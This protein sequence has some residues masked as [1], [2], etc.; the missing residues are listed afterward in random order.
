MSTIVT[1]AGKGS[2]LTWNEADNNFTNLNTDK[3]QSGNTAAAL[4]ITSATIN[5]GTITG[6][7]LNGSLGATTPST[8]VATSVKIGTTGTSTVGA[9]V[10][11]N[12]TSNSSALQLGNNSGTGDNGGALLYGSSG[13]EFS[14]YSYTGA[15][16]AETYVRKF[17][18]SGTLTTSDQPL[19]VTGDLTTTGNTILGNAST[20]TLNVGNGGLVKDANGAVM[21]NTTTPL[22]TGSNLTVNGSVVS[23]GLT[24]SIGGGTNIANTFNVDNYI[25]NTRFYSHGADASTIGSYTWHNVSS[26]GSIDNSTMTLDASGNLLVGTTGI[27]V[28][29]FPGIQGVSASGGGGTFLSHS[30][31]GTATRQW[32]FGH[33]NADQFVIYG[34]NNTTFNTG[35]YIAWGAT[36][37][38][39]SSDE[40]KKDIIEPITDAIDKVSTLRAVIGKYKTDEEGTRRSFLI[41]Q[42]VLAVL[43]EAVDATNPDDLGVQ[44]TEVI[45]LLVAAI[46][47]QQALI[48]SL[49]ARLEVLE[50]K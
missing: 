6:T 19:T 39:A 7:A 12:S 11:I 15:V 42:D 34:Y 46:K 20:D 28:G 40:R 10:V 5:G 29:T 44:Y 49:T 2:P 18:I 8:V 9:G 32:G 35:A 22:G 16:G 33:N 43:P 3:L 26:N 25:G 36:S 31:S 48:T 37:W 38:T 27:S 17:H 45:P 24:V 21:I 41:A 50:A 30:T 13:N 23:T 1:R 14:I 47:E 4:T